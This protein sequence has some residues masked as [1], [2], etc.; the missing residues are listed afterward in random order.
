MTK[1]YVTKSNKELDEYYKDLYESERFQS[2]YGERI[3]ILNDSHFSRYMFIKAMETI[4]DKL[5]DES[6]DIAV[7]DCTI[8]NNNA[9]FTVDSRDDYIYETYVMHLRTNVGDFCCRVVPPHSAE[10]PVYNDFEWIEKMYEKMELD[11][12]F[13]DILEIYDGKEH[14]PVV[15]V[16]FDVLLAMSDY[17]DKK[18]SADFLYIC[19]EFYSMIRCV[20]EYSNIRIKKILCGNKL[21]MYVYNPYFALDECDNIDRMI[22]NEETGNAYMIGYSTNFKEPRTD[23]TFNNM[24]LI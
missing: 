21:N 15:N 7:L 6:A 17:I 9:V 19:R 22:K 5:Q 3:K 23:N 20:N 11:M 1:V 16:Q 10:I 13:Q 18:H 12:H 4:S 24:K 14:Y 8:S 2:E